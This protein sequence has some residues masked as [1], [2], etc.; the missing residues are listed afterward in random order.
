MR[1]YLTLWLKTCIY[2]S[3]KCFNYTNCCLVNMNRENKNISIHIITTLFVWFS[4]GK[5]DQIYVYMYVYWYDW[6]L[7]FPFL[8]LEKQCVVSLFST[9]DY[10]FLFGVFS[11]SFTIMLLFHLCVWC[12]M[13]II[14]STLS[15]CS[16]YFLF[17]S[18][19]KENLVFCYIFFIQ[20]HFCYWTWSFFSV[21]FMMFVWHL[22][23]LRNIA[24]DI[25]VY[26]DIVSYICR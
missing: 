18:K 20:N 22:D 19:T 1:K 21:H 16:Y 10:E 5:H 23:L 17:W 11:L 26:D 25:R 8:I 9:C 15:F 7:S 3:G 13:G 12:M 6:C 2:I 4:A 24:T 14:S